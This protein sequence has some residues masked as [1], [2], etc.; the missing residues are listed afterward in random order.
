M[1]KIKLANW[2]NLLKEPFPPELTIELRKAVSPDFESKHFA[3]LVEIKKAI[4]HVTEYLNLSIDLIKKKAS[5]KGITVSEYGSS[6]HRDRCMTCLGRY[7]NH[8]P[9]FKIKHPNAKRFSLHQEDVTEFLTSIG[10]TIGEI[11]FF[12]QA[13]DTRLQLIEIYHTLILVFNHIELTNI[14]LEGT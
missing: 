5:A 9:Y 13:R 7:R 3:E 6:C 14:T 10:M 4:D 8:Y 1:Q 12:R 2:K 11:N